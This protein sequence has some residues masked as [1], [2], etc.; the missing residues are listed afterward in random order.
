VAEFQSALGSRQYDIESR[1]S[2]KYGCSRGISGTPIFLANGVIIDGAENW[3]ASTW[4]V[5]IQ[6][7][8]VV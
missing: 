3:D 7:K 5:F 1:S 6:A 2:W 4:T 8:T